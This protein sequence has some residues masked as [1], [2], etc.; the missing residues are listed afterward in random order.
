MK[1]GFRGDGGYLVAIRDD[2]TQEFVQHSLADHF[3]VSSSAWIGLRNTG[4]GGQYVLP[5]GQA[6][7]L[8]LV[9]FVG[10]TLFF[11]FLVIVVVVVVVVVVFIVPFVSLPLPPPSPQ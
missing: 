2:Q 9:G 8:L 1:A 7:L 11:S 4:P 5:D 6:R 3:S 10:L